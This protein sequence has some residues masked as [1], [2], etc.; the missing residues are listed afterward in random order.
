MNQCCWWS[1]WLSD[2]PTVGCC[3]IAGGR[4]RTFPFGLCNPPLHTT[5]PIVDSTIL[6]HLS[7]CVTPCRSGSPYYLMP[8]LFQHMTFLHYN[9]SIACNTTLELDSAYSQSHQHLFMCPFNPELYWHPSCQHLF[10]LDSNAIFNTR[11]KKDLHC[12]KKGP[13]FRDQ[14]LRETLF[15]F[16]VSH[17]KVPFFSDLGI[18][19]L[20]NLFTTDLSAMIL[21]LCYVDS[22]IIGT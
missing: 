14:V 18:Y 15:T 8:F 13:Y 7:Q 6:Y 9:L 22:K 3:L 5:I 1:W 2:K 21:Y 4:G 11:E 17:F 16:W 10:L 19:M 20:R 12:S